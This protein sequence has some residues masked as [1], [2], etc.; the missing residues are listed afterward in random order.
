[1]TFDIFNVS[2]NITLKV[3]T[4]YAIISLPAKRNKEIKRGGDVQSTPL[5][6]LVNSKINHLPISQLN[7]H[8]SWLSVPSG[9]KTSLHT[10]S[11]V[12][13]LRSVL[14]DSRKRFSVIPFFKQSLTKSYV[15]C[16]VLF[17]RPSR[18]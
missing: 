2:T 11:Y 14:E 4:R 6:D 7:N 8:G 9:L 18:G 12:D 13:A 3:F 10:V 17:P 1:M 16:F 5:R 15:P